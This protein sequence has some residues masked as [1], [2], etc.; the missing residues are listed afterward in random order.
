MRVC[1]GLIFAPTFLEK[2]AEDNS[3]LHRLINTFCFGL[4]FSIGFIRMEK[5]FNPILGET[6]QGMIDGCPVYAEQV[7]HH[8]PISSL[9][10]KGRG[11][12]VYGSLEAKVEMSF[13]SGSGINDGIMNV[14]FDEKDL[15]RNKITFFTPPGQISGLLY[16]DRKLSLVKKSNYIDEDNR[17]VL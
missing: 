3:P 5:P 14:C 12:T 4:G 8:P 16:G 10:M 17:L 11:Y 7:S 6:F 13:N 15:K 9:L 2:A 1:R